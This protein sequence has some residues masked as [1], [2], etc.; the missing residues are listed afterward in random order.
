MTSVIGRLSIIAAL[1]LWSGPA[2]AQQSIQCAPRQVVLDYHFD[3][4][5]QSRVAIG[6][7]DTENVIE[8]LVADDGTFTFIVTR[9]DGVSCRVSRGRAWTEV[10]PP[11]KGPTS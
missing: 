3:N 10:P 11:I 2:V 4:E 1:V 6:I 8:L 5:K 9:P 7:L